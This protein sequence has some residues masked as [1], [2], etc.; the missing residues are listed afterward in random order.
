M[1][2]SYLYKV[3]IASHRNLLA[4]R[5]DSN[6]VR[7]SPS[8]TGPLTF[9]MICRFSSP[10]NSTLTWVHWPWEPV[11]PR[12]LITRAKTTGF[13]I[14][15]L[16]VQQ[17]HERAAEGNERDPHARSWQVALN[18]KR[19]KMWTSLNV[20]GIFVIYFGYKSSQNSVQLCFR[21]YFIFSN[22]KKF[23]I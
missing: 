9:L 13:S 10:R 3:V 17:L 23:F 16:H 8:R 15:S 1:I 4:S 11:R 18:R 5:S 12:T 2:T 21:S 7:R 20:A 19:R 14:L 22:K 6:K